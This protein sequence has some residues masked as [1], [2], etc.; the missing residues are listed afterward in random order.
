ME[1]LSVAMTNLKDVGHSAAASQP[2]LMS[3]TELLCSNT[4]ADVLFN[5]ETY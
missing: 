4:T 1:N 2:R 3:G 5:S